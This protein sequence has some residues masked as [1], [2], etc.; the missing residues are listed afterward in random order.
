MKHFD[1]RQDGGPVPSPCINICRM[2][3]RTGLC[4]GCQRTIDE[5]AA[6]GMA[7]EDEKRAVWRAIERRRR[8]ER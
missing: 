3:E 5:I 4:Q 1:P 2:D 6:W 8:P 7:S